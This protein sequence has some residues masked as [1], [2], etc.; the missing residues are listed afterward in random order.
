MWKL[1]DALAQRF[2][3]IARPRPACLPLPQRIHKLSELADTAAMTGDPSVASTVYNQAALIA[4]DVGAADTARAICHQHAAAYL[5]ATPLTARAAIHALEPVIN[6]ARLQL[7][8]GHA[9]N[10]CQYLRALFDA[11]TTGSAV[12]VEDVTVPADLVENADDRQEIR[13]WLWT[14]I[15]ADGTRALTTAGRWTEAFD[16]V[17]AHHGVGL[18]MLDGR[19]VAVL[20]A[21]KS[22]DNVA[23]SDL[24]TTT[25]AGEAWECAVTDCLTVLCHRTSGRPWRR[26]L[27]NLVTTYLARPDQDD[28]AVFDTVFGLALLDMLD[29]TEVPT[30][31]LMVAELHRRTARTSNGRTAREILKHPLFTA[32][33]TQQEVQE[34]RALLRTCAL[35]TGTLQEEQR[36]QLTA[37]V[38]ISDRVIRRSVAH[39]DLGCRY[40]VPGP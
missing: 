2:P 31:R 17:Q 22:G 3:L 29:A 20:A 19:Q 25:A 39:G 15:L 13:A 10:G 36:N 28:L 40:G 30:A 14:V 21:L 33:A 6:L 23:A 9:D 11:V 12:H 4:S 26:A 35:G 27:Q 24:L 18:R 16:H 34:C 1:P 5:H 38:R 37:A 8:A 32:L 7:R